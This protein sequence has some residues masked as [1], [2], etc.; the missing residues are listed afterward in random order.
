MIDS[1]IKRILYIAI[2]AALNN[3]LDILQVLVDMVFVGKVSPVA[4]ASVG[5]SM[6]FLWVLY[7]I[8]SIFSVSTNALVARFYGAKDYSSLKKVISANLITSILISIP[9]TILVCVFSYKFFFLFGKNEEIALSATNYMHILSIS[10]PFLFI[11]AVF[12]STSN[13]FGDTKTPLV[14]GIIGNLINT[15]LDYTLILGNLGFPRLEI[16]GAAIATTTA[17]IFEVVIYLLLIFFRKLFPVSISFDKAL[18]QKIFEIGIPA[19]LERFIGSIS[20]LFFIYIISQYGTYVLAGY[21][22]GL[23]VEGLAF[24]IGFGFSIAAM[25]LVGQSLGEGN[26]KKAYKYGLKTSL[27]SAFI[28]Q[29]IGIFM[30]FYPEIFIS[31]FTDDSKTVE[32]ASLYLKVVA[33]SQFPLAIDFVLSGALRGAG[34]TKLTLFINTGSLWVFRI[35]P[36]LFA[37]FYLKNLLFVYFI[38]ILETFIKASII[39]YIFKH[40]RWIEKEGKYAR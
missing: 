25:T 24:M 20:F 18:V 28:M 3:L 16:E 35:I 5:L 11:G 10:F 1:D 12:V 37:T 6:N 14:I 40:G 36:S 27:T 39:W 23:R 17:Y 32:E 9:L 8:I 38:I 15:F 34:A 13:G 31:I 26:K 4:I 29:F 30:F 21:Q 7:A 22:I 19:G 2:P 33:V